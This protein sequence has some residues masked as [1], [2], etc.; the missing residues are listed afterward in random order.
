MFEERETYFIVTKLTKNC[1][2]EKQN[3]PRLTEWQGKTCCLLTV[4]Q[5]YFLSWWLTR[6]FLLFPEMSWMPFS[7]FTSVVRDFIPCQ[8]APYR[9]L[10]SNYKR[11][12]KDAFC[13]WVGVRLG[14]DGSF[15]QHVC[16][17]NYHVNHNKLQWTDALSNFYLLTLKEFLWTSG[18]VILPL[19][20][21]SG[22][23]KSAIRLLVEMDSEMACFVAAEVQNNIWC[24]H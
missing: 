5:H 8:W 12:A 22:L 1:R 4:S 10:Y 17:Y 18:L 2:P 23:P 3:S 20:L 19:Q 24:Q 6:T 11:L 16:R 7:A 9:N 21:A 14:L 15:E 13:G